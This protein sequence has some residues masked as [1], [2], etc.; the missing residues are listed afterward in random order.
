MSLD[1]TRIA[2]DLEKLSARHGFVF[3]L[4]VGQI[5]R[6]VHLTA[7][8]RFDEA[9]TA[10]CDGFEVHMLRN[11]GRLFYSF[12][13]WKLGELLLQAGHAS[14]SDRLMGQA[15]DVA[16]DHQDRAYLGELLD[17]QGRARQAVG[18]LEGA[19]DA[20]RSAMST[21][22]ALGAVPARVR[23]ATHL[24]EL[25]RDSGRARSARDG[26]RRNR[27]QHRPELLW[28]SRRV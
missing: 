11:G 28:R 7:Q 26:W 8:G 13:A 3:Y 24:A 27:P 15:M 2:A 14:E 10:I 5:F 23:A 25:L 6:G 21:A 9:E 12:H 22:L 4:G 20:L 16:L 18:D 17:V 1:W 19:E